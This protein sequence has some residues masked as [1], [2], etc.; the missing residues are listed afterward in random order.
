MSAVPQPKGAPAAPGSES[1]AGSAD[2]DRDT[3]HG[4][5][6]FLIREARALDEER[7]HDWLAM[8]APDIRYLLP[9]REVRYRK[10]TAPIGTATGTNIY[11]EDYAQLEMRIRRLDTGL[12]WFEDPRNSV[13]R[14]IAN[15]DA[16]W[17][18]APDEVQAWSNFIVY[19]NRRQRDETWLVGARE[20]RLRRADGTWKLARRT[21]TLDQRVVLDKNLHVFL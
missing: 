18:D 11:D 20:D 7:F 14:V 21:I 1:G 15:I 19:R 10:D 6:R 5:E 9:I 4:I 3:L 13:R 2:V 12:V 17:A 16:V 8:L